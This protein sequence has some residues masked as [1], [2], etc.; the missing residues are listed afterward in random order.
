MGHRADSYAPTGHCAKYFQAFIGAER[1]QRCHPLVARTSACTAIGLPE[2][3]GG[4]KDRFAT[5]SSTLGR[6]L[7]HGPRVSAPREFESAAQ[8]FRAELQLQPGNHLAKY[9]LGYGL[10]AQGH[11]AEAIPILRDVIKALPRY[12]LAYFE[13]GRALLD[14]GDS[15][16]A[17]ENLE[18]AKNL[19]PEHDAVYFQLSRAYRRANRM[20]E[21][22]QALAQYQKLIEGNR[23]KKR[24]SLEMNRP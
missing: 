15:S 6:S 9:H 20:Q 8:E 16:G 18:T 19:A 7:L 17:I 2:R 14:Q 11:A 13:L 10:L 12:E 4:T 5:R 24:E 21:A 22:A 23:A 1:R 3:L